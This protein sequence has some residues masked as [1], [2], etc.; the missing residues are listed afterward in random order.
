MTNK[1]ATNIIKKISDARKKAFKNFT[2]RQKN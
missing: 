2:Q 1:I